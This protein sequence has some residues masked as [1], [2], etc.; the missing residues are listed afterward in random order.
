MGFAKS[1]Y[2][3]IFLIMHL[4]V[5]QGRYIQAGSLFLRLATI[6]ILFPF[7]VSFGLPFLYYGI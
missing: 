1:N 3:V 2:S 6:F 5:S 7:V 4:E